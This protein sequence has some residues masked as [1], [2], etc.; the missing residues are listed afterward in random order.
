M[1]LNP[2]LTAMNGSFSSRRDWP[3]TEK[4]SKSKNAGAISFS[5]TVFS[6]IAAV[7]GSRYKWCKSYAI[8]Q[9]G[10]EKHAVKGSALVPIMH[11]YHVFLGNS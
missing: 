6:P 3:N 10:M 1:R 4:K 11:V 2:I 8:Q 7:Q 9:V 5:P